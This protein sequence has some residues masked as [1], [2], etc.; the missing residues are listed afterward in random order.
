[1]TDGFLDVPVRLRTGYNRSV[2]HPVARPRTPSRSE[3][4]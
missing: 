2:G 4:K 1:V 3:S